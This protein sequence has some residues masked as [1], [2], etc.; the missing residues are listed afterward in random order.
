MHYSEFPH[1]YYVGDGSGP[2]TLF[3]GDLEK[4]NW[5]WVFRGDAL[6]THYDMGLNAYFNEQ[7]RSTMQMHPSQA[8]AALEFCM[9][10]Q[11]TDAVRRRLQEAQHRWDG[12]MILAR[13]ANVIT[14][15]F[16]RHRR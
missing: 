12:P 15:N 4:W 6:D 1:S 14:A 8:L 13:N 2:G 10:D 7:Q 5:R 11:V 16:G 3:V 9:P